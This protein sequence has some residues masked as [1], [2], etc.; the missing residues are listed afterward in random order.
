MAG[1]FK[2]SRLFNGVKNLNKSSYANI[3]TLKTIYKKSNETT[4]KDLLKIGAVSAFVGGSV[5]LAYEFYKRGE[6]R[7]NFQLNG[8]MQ[9]IVLLK[10]KP[11]IQPSRK[12]VYPTDKT[13]LQLVLFQYQSC[14][15][16]CKVRVFLDYYG[17]SYDVVEV[18]PVFRTQIKWSPYKKV[19]ILLT[20]VGDSYEP[21]NDSS[22]IISI[23]ASFLNDPS[24]PIKE[25]SSY[26]SPTAISDLDGGLKYEV[27][28]KYYLMYQKG[29]PKNKS[30]NDIVEERKW[31]QWSD[32]ILVH[33]LSPNVYRTFKESYETFSWFREFGHWDEYFSKI[34]IY[35]ATNVGA[36][37]MYFIG[38]RLKAKYNMNDDVRESLYKQTN[39]WLDGLKAQNTPFMGG[40]EPNLSDLTVYGIFKSI[41]GCE[42]FKDLLRSTKLGTW[43][44]AMTE[45]V[46][47]HSGSKLLNIK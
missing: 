18:D 10:D 34:R 46:Q 31:R 37:A 41:E 44:N 42:A 11:A 2:F 21:L 15:F 8:T 3:N 9:N 13:G 17:I 40:E 27:L 30:L 35:I 7:K 28:N 36:V 23:L 24:I 43:F 20:K 39:V 22:V 47:E 16:C 12:V 29:V 6:R 14:P 25:L 33:T 32:E 38:K 19:P 1:L 26:Y 4:V 45:K 5:C